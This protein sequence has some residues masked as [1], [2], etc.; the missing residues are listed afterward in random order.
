MFKYILAIVVKEKNGV[1]NAFMEEE[2]EKWREVKI[3]L[4]RSFY[5]IKRSFIK[6]KKESIWIFCPEKK[7][8]K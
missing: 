5:G 7:K 3:I 2:K 1:R 6:R 4:E 8:K